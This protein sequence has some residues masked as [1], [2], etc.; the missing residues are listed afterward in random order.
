MEFAKEPLT[1]PDG[2]P[3]PACFQEVEAWMRN[4]PA[5]HER[6]KDNKQWTRPRWINC[7]WITGYLA[8]CAIRQ[9]RGPAFPTKLEGVLGFLHARIRPRFDEH[10]LAKMSL[11]EVAA[12]IYE[13]LMPEEM[14]LAWN[15]EKVIQGWIDLDALIR[16]VCLSI[17]ENLK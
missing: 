14:F 7:R 3:N 11:C 13:E 16:N 10:C 6:M 1:T 8:C 15:D 12:L 17:M 5:I 2:Q 4:L 9:V